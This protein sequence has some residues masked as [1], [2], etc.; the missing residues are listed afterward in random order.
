LSR[1]LFAGA[2]LPTRGQILERA[3]AEIHPEA[4]LEYLELVDPISFEPT[5]VNEN[6]ALLIVAAKVGNVRLLDNVIIDRK[7]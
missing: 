1:A 5:E 3:K 6:S 7:S 2:T 4:K